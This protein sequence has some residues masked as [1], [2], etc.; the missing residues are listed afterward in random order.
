MREPIAQSEL[1]EQILALQPGDH[2]CLFYDQDPAEQMPALIPFIRDGLS[3][4]EQCIYVVDDQTVGELSVRLAQ[5]GIDLEKELARSALKLWTRREWRQ[6]GELSSARKLRQVS[7]FIEEA[8]ESGFKGIRFAVEMTWTLGPELKVEHLERWET[9]LNTLF[10]PEFPVRI[11]CQ[12]NRSRLHPKAMLNALRTH[13]LVI[14]RENI[15]PNLFY[16]APLILNGN[17]E[18]NPEPA[19]VDWMVSQL[20]RARAAAQQRELARTGPEEIAK[21]AQRLAAI[22]ESSDDA[23]VSK[24]LNGVITSWNRGAE[25]IFGYSPDEIIGKPITLLIPPERYDEEPTILA[26][27]RRGEPVDHYETVRCRKDGSLVNISLTVSPIRNAEGT[28]IGASKIARDI[29]GRMRAEEELRK[30]KDDLA[31]ANRELAKR[32]YERTV[33]LA[34]AEAALARDMEEQNRLQEQLR[35][36]QKMESIG[37]LAGGIAHDFNNILNIIKGHVA[38]LGQGLVSADEEGA[39]KVIDQAIERGALTVR[40]LLTL[41]RKTEA[42]LLSMNLN[43]TVSELNQLLRRTLPKNI[44]MS[45]QLDPKLPSVMA[46]PSQIAQALLNLCVNARDA[47]PAGGALTLRTTV[48]HGRSIRDRFTEIT[49]GWYVCIEIVDTGAGM[50]ANVRS[51]IFEPFFTTKKTGEGTGLG[52]SV[53]YAIIKNHHGFI[54]VESK[55]GAGTAFRLYLAVAGSG[56]G[57]AGEK[58]TVIEQR[59]TTQSGEANPANGRH[60]I[61]IA[62]DEGSMARL[63]NQSLSKRG[64]TVLIA[65]DGEEAIELYHRAKE[66]IDIV[67]LD[68]GLPKIA[69]WDV[70]RRLKD[71][72]PDIR[73]VVTSGYIEPELKTKMLAAGVKAVVYKPYTITAIAEMLQAI[74]EGDAR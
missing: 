58:K 35:Q 53:V 61:L 13:P 56:K 65:A 21:A 20:K 63:L 45:L 25:R 59:K 11:I 1:T 42:Q 40:Q 60:T 68:I 67:L 51:R 28:I 36:A 57:A 10:G 18:E 44:T 49:G 26:R 33:D 12:Y 73:I 47:M 23:I 31:K 22:V 14:L 4:D 55:P 34:Q 17:G 3:A 7:G 62:E 46:D 41:A 52:L 66:S 64:Y 27:I 19:Q 2:L 54:D 39:F 43:A 29:T 72:N 50:E 9:S 16:Q 74:L 30:I 71:E 8:R 5:S 24:D 38:I 69:G 15:H 48:V 6:P 32:V 37:T 70:I